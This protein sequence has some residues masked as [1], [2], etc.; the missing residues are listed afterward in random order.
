MITL[1]RPDSHTMTS[2]R[3]TAL[4]FLL[5]SS[6]CMPSPEPS[7]A[8]TRASSTDRWV[9]T[10][11]GLGPVLAGMPLS[12]L[13]DT[14]GVQLRAA[15]PA[16]SR[17]AY[18]EPA[19][20]PSGTRIMI[21]ND[22]V[23]RIDVRAPGVRTTEGVGV[24]DTEGD[25]LARYEGRIRVAPHKYTGPQGHYLIVTAPSDS[26][27]GIVFETDG[28]RVVNYRAG[29]RSAVDLVEGCS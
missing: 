10:S 4:T 3:R 20:L 21:E 11:R 13:G 15:Y 8:A 12:A 2:V 18:V 26:A 29:R 19:A 7:D 23:A 22:T 28:N 27:H 6:A 14:L 25:V 17:C 9:V 16:G 5:A 24:G 1:T